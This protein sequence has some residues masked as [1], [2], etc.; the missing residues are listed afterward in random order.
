MTSRTNLQL[1]YIEY[2][3]GTSKDTRVG[4]TTFF[5]LCNEIT[6]SEEVLLGSIDYVQ[7]LRLTE[8]IESLQT[9]IDKYFIA[10]KHNII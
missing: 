10:D 1:W 2:V 5:S 3:A 9:V 8:P 4:R 7:T 6:Y